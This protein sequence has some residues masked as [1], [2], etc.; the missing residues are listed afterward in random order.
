M[1]IINVTRPQEAICL[2]NVSVRYRVPRERYTTFKEF[3]IRRVQRRV[4]HDEF[5]ALK[6]VSLNI[7]KGEIFGVIG[8][9]GAG[10]ST[11]LKLVARVL[12][13]TLGRVVVVGRVAPL[14]ELGAGF[15][16][17]LTGREN[18][19]LN[20]ALLGFTRRE[21]NNRVDAIIAFAEINDFIE[22]PLRTYSS[23]MMAR[24]GFAVATDVQPEVLLVDEV[25][26]VGDESF[27][28]KCQARIQEFRDHGA[29]ILM[30]SHSSASVQAICQRAAWI[31]H[32]HLMDIGLPESVIQKYHEATMG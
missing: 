1:G 4:N 17:D 32:G 3:V 24:L 12:R 26:G 5:W 15:H 8:R 9:N 23:G 18:I 16:P 28:I 25:L 2:E 6:D 27:Q 20:G 29:T 11:L 13:P 30:V 14:L 31:D 22:A 19:Y 10:K 7:F 21:I